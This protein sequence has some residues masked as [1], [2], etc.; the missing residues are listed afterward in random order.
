MAKKTTRK[1]RRSSG[2]SRRRKSMSEFPL[3][4]RGKSRKRRRSGSRKKGL[5][6]IFS[7]STFKEGGKGMLSGS[8]G[9]GISFVVDM[10][11]PKEKPGLR[12]ISQ[13]GAA[14]LLGGGF[15]LPNVGAGVA[16]AYSNNLINQLYTKSL[17]EMENNDYADPN[18]LDAFPDA[19][20][21]DGNA[22]YLAE[23]G[24]FYYLEEFSLAE[25]GTYY[26]NEDMQANLYPGYINPVV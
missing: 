26:L 11:V 2:T 18:A 10:L 17:S 25:D 23:D 1:R 24:N 21:E 15:N 13:L 3:S 20:D 22:M 19:L 4:R 5:S 6:E 7:P 9:G 8:L 14:I 16:G 12:A